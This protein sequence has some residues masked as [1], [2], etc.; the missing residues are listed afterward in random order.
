MGLE[1]TT[2][3]TTIRTG[4]WGQVLRAHI[5]WLSLPLGVSWF[6]SIWTP[7]WTPIPEASFDRV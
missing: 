4:G 3:W 7:C 6:C 5:Y 1:R 2:A